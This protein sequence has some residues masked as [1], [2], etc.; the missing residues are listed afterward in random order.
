MFFRP[1]TPL[2]DIQKWVDAQLPAVYNTAKNG[3]EIAIIQHKSKRTNEQ[4][5]FLMVVCTHIVKLYHETGYVL[6]GLQPWAMQP[7][8]V[9]EYWKHRYGTDK[10]STLDKAE[11]TKFIDFIQQTMVEE[12]CGNYEILTTDSAYL[13]SLLEY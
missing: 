13:K 7:I 8:I 4:N 2:E 10:S 5:R 3:I 11:F 1:D 9:K 6:P 12:T